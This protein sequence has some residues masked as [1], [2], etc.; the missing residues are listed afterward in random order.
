MSTLSFPTTPN[1]FHTSRPILSHFT[2]P[3]PCVEFHPL[4]PSHIPSFL[5]NHFPYIILSCFSY[6]NPLAHSHSIFSLLFHSSSHFSFLSCIPASYYHKNIPS[7]NESWA[8]SGIENPGRTWHQPQSEPLPAR[9]T[10]GECL[11]KTSSM[12]VSSTDTMYP[13]FARARQEAGVEA[14]MSTRDVVDLM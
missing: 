13:M 9:S 11:A 10:C 4:S 6:L 8:S 1:A 7:I 5:T 2:L 12:P 3:Y 14:R